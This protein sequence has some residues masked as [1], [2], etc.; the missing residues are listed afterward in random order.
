MT[1][2][3]AVWKR[4]RTAK[5]VRTRNAQLNAVNAVKFATGS[6]DPGA[7]ESASIHRKRTP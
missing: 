6:R 5:R 1:T 7:R 4:T 2:N 3:V